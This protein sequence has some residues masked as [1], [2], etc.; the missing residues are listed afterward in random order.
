MPQHTKIE[1]AVVAGGAVTMADQIMQA[2]RDDSHH[3]K[4]ET[5]SHYLKA[6]IAGAIAVGA[7]EMLKR[8]EADNPYSL[9]TGSLDHENHGHHKHGS[10]AS[11]QTTQTHPVN[12]DGHTKDIMAEVLG[13][14]SLGR[15]MMGHRDHPIIKLIAEGLGA[16]AFAR[17]A[18]KDLVHN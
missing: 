3:D 5:Q 12:K 18:D 4:H 15:Q 17:E 6:A 2:I 11:Q 9:D 10:H 7:Y 8:D 14:Y 16:A 1:T 13:A